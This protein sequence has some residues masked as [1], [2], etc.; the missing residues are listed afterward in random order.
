MIEML[1]GAGLLLLG[2]VLGVLGMLLIKTIQL[3]GVEEE[4][5]GY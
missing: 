2:V 1:V 4:D 5:D 3:S